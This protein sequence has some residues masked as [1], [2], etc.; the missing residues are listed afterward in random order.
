MTN[1]L[2]A[3]LESSI[4]PTLLVIGDLILDRYLWG[5]VDRISPEAPIPLLRVDREEE[6]LGGAG[7]V[8]AML[9]ALEVDV[10]VAAVVGDDD[11]GKRVRE[12]LGEAG[13]D[14]SGVLVD[15]SR[16]TTVKQRFLGRA[17]SRH[18]QQIIRVDQEED[19][20]LEPQMAA[21]LLEHIRPQL[22]AADLILVSDYN[23]GV[24]AQ[25]MVSAVIEAT[26]GRTPVIAD[27]IRGGDYHRYAGCAC[28]TPNRLEAGLAIGRTINSPQEGI[29]AARALLDFGIE[30]AIVTLDRDGMAWA[31]H[32]GT[33]GIS[34]SRPR[35]VYDI[36]GA[37]DMV[38]SI[39]GFGLAAGLEYPA[40][41]E[42]ANLAGGL[43]VERL[44]VVP[45]TRE[46]LLRELR[47]G[48]TT[49]QQKVISCDDL[50]VELKRRRQAG[51]RIVM[52]NGCFDL[53]HP[54][55]VAT[56]QE[57]RALGD[58]LVVGLNSDRSVRSLKGAPRPIMDQHGRSEMLAALACVDYVVLFD[59]TSVEPLVARILPDVL[60]KAA[61]YEVD[62]VVGH[63]IVT[64][65]GGQV[66]RTPMHGEYSTSELIE[67]IQQLDSQ[68]AADGPQ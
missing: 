30:S 16:P 46:D 22:D 35:E 63:Q 8:V 31:R 66:V 67:K 19:G 58:C 11:A 43:E 9:A 65:H 14:A 48:S 21:R 10:H 34:P 60:T 1:E 50:L 24:C 26:A 61:Q 64:A 28:I 7:S 18:P 52:T 36:T 3:R 6:R 41:V 45:L 15:A 32:D 54:G 5:N 25:Q 4:R 12:L 55:H 47:G 51:Q 13:A 38:L 40:L 17:Q 57:A 23:K 44:G 2:V 56:L 68:L 33:T 39:I 59:E 53:L 62:Q 27:P 20:P 42:L 29:D 37:G 49:R